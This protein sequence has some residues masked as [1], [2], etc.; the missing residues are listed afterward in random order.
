M[1]KHVKNLV[2]DNPG[3]PSSNYEI[4]A[5]I[6]HQERWDGKGYPRRIAAEDIPLPAHCLAIADALTQ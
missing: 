3:L 2:Y 6:G 4:P 5:A 1:Q